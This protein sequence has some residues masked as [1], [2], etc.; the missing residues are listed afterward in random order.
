MNAQIQEML[1][2]KEK[3][4]SLVDFVD[5]GLLIV[6][7]DGHI[8][9]AS[10]EAKEIFPIEVPNS[11]SDLFAGSIVCESLKE[12]KELIKEELSLE[13]ANQKIPLKLSLRLAQDGGAIISFRD[14]SHRQNLES[15]RQNALED[16]Q[17]IFN[18]IGE[19][20]F[21]VD[22]D[23]KILKANPAYIKLN[24]LDSEKELLEIKNFAQQLYVDK[25]RNKE[26]LKQISK[27]G[28]VTDFESEVYAYKTRERIW[29]SEDTK[30]IKNE[31]G[32]ILYY[33][34]VCRDITAQKHSQL[35][36]ERWSKFQNQL[37]KTSKHLLKAGYD[38]KFYDR[39]IEAAI[40]IL[41]A[42]E[43][44]VLFIRNNRNYFRAVSSINCDMP[45]SECGFT[46]KGLKLPKKPVIVNSNMMFIKAS[47]LKNYPDKD[48]IEKI[49]CC[50]EES[51]TIIFPIIDANRIIALFSLSTSKE[52]KL[53]ADIL[54]MSHI[55]ITT[56]A[57]LM[58]RIQLGNEL[59]RS[60]AELTQ[61]ANY[62]SLTMLPNR[63]FFL[64]NLQRAIDYNLPNESVTLIFLDVD[65]LKLVNDSIGHD[66]GDSLLKEVAERLRSCMR[67][68]DAIARL[69]GDEFTIIVK[70]VKSQEDSINIA[71]KILRS[72]E[73]PFNFN[74][75][76]IFVSASL[77]LAQYPEHADNATDLI[78]R[79]DSA[80]YH[81]KNISKGR[82][83]FYTDNLKEKAS[84]RMRLEQDLK[85]AIREHEFVLHYQPRIELKSN[86]IK[87]VEALVR[88]Q[89]PE[90][91]LIMPND[92]IPLA[93][94]IGIIDELGKMVLI[95]ACKQAK[96]WQKE[97]KDLRVAVNL[98]VKQLQQV[99]I[100]EQ[101]FEVLEN[102]GLE[103]SQL[104]LEITESAAMAN[105][106]S[107]ISKLD[108]LKDAGIHIAIDDFGTAYSSLNYLKRLPISSL[109]IDKSFLE[110]IQKDNF[111]PKDAAIIRSIATL[112]KN[113]DLHIVAEGIETID[114][115]EF[116][117]TLECDEVQGYIYS[118]PLSVLDLEGYLG[119]RKNPMDKLNL[120]DPSD[121]L[122]GVNL[123]N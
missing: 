91:G 93:E 23:G 18:N 110:D 41:P 119:N 58:K 78:K 103:P 65:G 80:M 49:F 115:L 2:E 36:L 14:L 35:K 116:V 96:I 117:N 9:F 74:N 21:R 38:M 70:N 32:E 33:D 15:L 98:S 13:I 67:K 31:K 22:L 46:S 66:A 40:K 73:P 10:K 34:G 89:H 106:E 44:G 45:I 6:D 30:A 5:L 27:T 17:A 76:K 1:K 105:I 28:Q 63:S 54:E 108:A 82:Y 29:I 25:N 120:K 16:Y 57:V 43:S 11:I 61:L 37:I 69:G 87:S 111:N 47:H 99:D 92:F 107:N 94:E 55:F 64:T 50:Q 77:G 95:Q 123:A 85:R 48:L 79:A 71:K 112:G 88:W 86:K 81:S 113:L 101:I 39:L 104:E 72:L 114:Q 118:K 42:I 109:K 4:Q 84:K 121:N 52:S 90:R 3:F 56:I 24:G 7:K 68:T 62:D 60:N 75:N 97:G 100:V 12:H 59:A 51:E 20:I 26:F 83:S 53:A 19:G 8:L 122:I 102:N